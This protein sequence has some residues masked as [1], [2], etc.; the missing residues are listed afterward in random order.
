MTH[1]SMPEFTEWNQ[2]MSRLP[3]VL[4]NTISAVDACVSDCIRQ[5]VRLGDLDIAQ[6]Y[7]VGRNTLLR[8]KKYLEQ[9]RRNAEG[10]KN[11]AE[12][13]GQTEYFSVINNTAANVVNGTR[14][15][16]QRFGMNSETI[17]AL[18]TAL[19]DRTDHRLDSLNELH[20]AMDGLLVACG[21]AVA[22]GENFIKKIREIVQST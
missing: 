22:S 21:Y 1:A 9:A 16:T 11:A 13:V 20:V 15:L 4:D 3:D 18:M 14:D 10:W 19:D 7:A 5:E 2:V 12:Y 6:V 8:M 17:Q